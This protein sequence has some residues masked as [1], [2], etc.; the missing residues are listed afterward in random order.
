MQPDEK[1][2]DQNIASLSN[3]KS[4][5]TFQYEENTRSTN[6]P[7]NERIQWTNKEEGL[8]KQHTNTKQADK[9]CAVRRLTL[10][11][12][13]YFVQNGCYCCSW[14]N[15]VDF[16]VSQTAIVQFASQINATKRQIINNAH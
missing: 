16:S 2:N 5:Q 4:K 9:M 8:K 15:W 6:Q 10:V 13:V 11:A 1:M 12:Y 3:V 7:T 14:W